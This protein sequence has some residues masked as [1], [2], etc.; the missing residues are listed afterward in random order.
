M[1]DNE[2]SASTHGDKWENHLGDE[3]E[4]SLEGEEQQAVQ[5]SAA[6]FA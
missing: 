4:R 3:L 6:V 2:G 5:G 1:L